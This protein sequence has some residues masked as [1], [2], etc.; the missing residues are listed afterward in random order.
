MNERLIVHS[1]VEGEIDCMVLSC[2]FSHVVYMACAWEVV[3]E[4]V[5]R[6]SHHP[7]CQ[8]ER[9]LDTVSMMDVNIYVEY[10]LVDLEEFKYPKDTVVDVAES[11]SF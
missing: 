9:F 7:I 3:F 4:L 11:R 5:E 2:I 10:P 1:L 8:V 6:A